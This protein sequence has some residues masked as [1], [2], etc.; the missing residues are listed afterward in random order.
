MAPKY[1]LC[2]HGRRHGD[3]WPSTCGFAHSLD[4]LRYADN[5]WCYGLDSSS[6]RCGQSGVDIFYGQSY[7]AGQLL[8]VLVYM[9][10]EDQLPRWAR[11]VLWYY[12]ILPASAFACDGDFGWPLEVSSVAMLCLEIEVSPHDAQDLCRRQWP[13]SFLAAGFCDRIRSRLESEQVFPAYECRTTEPRQ[14]YA[15]LDC[16]CT[17]PNGWY[18]VPCQELGSEGHG[19]WVELE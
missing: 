12:R 13:R 8:R 17:G 9:C 16:R 2:K 18:M 10:E 7:S 6:H 11:M 15:L 14:A 19:A 4:E 1:A 3:S 5:R